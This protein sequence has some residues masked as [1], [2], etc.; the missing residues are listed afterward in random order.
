MGRRQRGWRQQHERELADYFTGKLAGEG[1]LHCGMSLGSGGGNPADC[2]PPKAVRWGWSE[3][4]RAFAVEV[5]L[6]VMRK[7]KQ[8]HSV[9]VLRAHYTP[10]AGGAFAGMSGMRRGDIAVAV[11]TDAVRRATLA[12]MEAERVRETSR[13]TDDHAAMTMGLDKKA[14]ELRSALESGVKSQRMRKELAA[15]SAHASVP[16][17]KAEVAAKWTREPL[18]SELLAT[19]RRACRDADDPTPGRAAAE[20]RKAAR[21]LRKRADSQAARDLETA[22][23]QYASVRDS[24]VFAQEDSEVRQ[25]I[26][27]IELG[28]TPRNTKRQHQ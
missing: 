13:R 11:M 8:M 18:H 21:D 25:F 7:H 1:G 14:E 10:R 3:R 27:S 24:M 19:L 4:S 23:D 20:R 22:R 28:T 17:I 26:A 15:L 6:D 5:A 9:D 12:W 16:D 2:S